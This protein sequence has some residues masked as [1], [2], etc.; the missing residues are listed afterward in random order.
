M[1][2]VLE[3]LTNVLWGFANHSEIQKQAYPQVFHDIYYGVETIFTTDL[4]DRT[5]FTWGFLL[6]ARQKPDKPLGEDGGRCPCCHA[7]ALVL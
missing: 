1:A 2:N 6:G 5:D 7:S 4:T 3:S